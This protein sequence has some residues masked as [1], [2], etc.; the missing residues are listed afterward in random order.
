M[1]TA[2]QAYRPARMINGDLRIGLST[3]RRERQFQ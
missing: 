2:Q 3:L 1:D